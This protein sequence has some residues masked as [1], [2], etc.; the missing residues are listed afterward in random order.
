MKIKAVIF[1][2][3]LFAGFLLSAGAS[4][5]LVTGF[6][7]QGMIP[8]IVPGTTGSTMISG[9]AQASDGGIIAGGF[10]SERGKNGIF[11]VKYAQDGSQV[12]HFGNRGVVFTSPFNGPLAAVTSGVPCDWATVGIRTNPVTGKIIVGA[13]IYNQGV[14]VGLG[15]GSY[16]QDGTLDTSFGMFAQGNSGARNGFLGSN[17]INPYALAVQ[18]DGKI[19]LGGSSSASKTDNNNVFALIRYHENGM[20]DMNFGNDGIVTLNLF[21][22]SQQRIYGV[23]IQPDGKIVTTGIVTKKNL[24]AIVTCR[25]NADGSVDE[26]FNAL[27]EFSS[28][29]YVV[30]TPGEN[31]LAVAF[32]VTLQPD[33]KIVVAGYGKFNVSPSQ[34]N[35]G[36]TSTLK[37]VVLRYNQD[38]SLDSTFGAGGMVVTQIGEQGTMPFDV[39][40]QQDGK[41][42]VAARATFYARNGSLVE[43][44]ATIRYT[45]TGKL[46]RTF[47]PDTTG[48]YG[49]PGVVITSF[50][51]FEVIPKGLILTPG[52]ITVGGY[53]M[54]AERRFYDGIITQYNQ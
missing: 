46:D 51:T 33:G 28:P 23:V 16:N 38:G 40:V 25:F 14:A 31:N 42:V 15:L 24:Y 6:G 11:L 1:G 8:F 9:F 5:S 53:G 49:V 34:A 50:S 13:H 29:G 36:T 12:I 43:T 52:K 45:S 27:N 48:L 32:A 2:G 22:G 44:F 4:G 20:L 41:M 35:H 54:D 10:A 3:F 18:G 30:S 19:V 47:G 26:T 17:S 21:P 7:E 37:L 39:A